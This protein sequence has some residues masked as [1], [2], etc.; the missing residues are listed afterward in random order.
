M[1]TAPS[2]EEYPAWSRE[3]SV[4]EK[5]V[6]RFPFVVCGGEVWMDLDLRDEF[7]SVFG[8]GLVDR[9]ADAAAKKGA[10]LQQ[11][12]ATPEEESRMHLWH[13][14]LLPTVLKNVL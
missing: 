9:M 7:D 8:V 4:D 2:Q 11:Q 12:G 6:V 1:G 14:W 3:P 13:L 5:V 10:C